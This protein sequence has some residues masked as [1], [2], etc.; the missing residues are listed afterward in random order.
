MELL[1]E[2]LRLLP[3][4][5]LPLS[6]SSLRLGT[7][8]NDGYSEEHQGMPK[9]VGKGGVLGEVWLWL[10]ELQCPCP[11]LHAAL[12]LPYCRLTTSFVFPVPCSCLR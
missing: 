12:R 6:L 8:H 9:Q 3:Q 4:A 1:G 5:T 7:H 10:A 2:P 11:G